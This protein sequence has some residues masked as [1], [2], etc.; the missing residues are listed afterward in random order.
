MHT[1][2]P[3]GP[4]PT[5]TGVTSGARDPELAPL[6]A[7]GPSTTHRIAEHVLREAW[8]TA[9]GAGDWAIALRSPSGRLAA[10]IS[11]FDPAM[12][13][14]AQLYRRA[15]RTGQVPRVQAEVTLHGGANLL[16]LE[17]L[18]PVA[19]AR[20]TAFHRSIRARAPG[21]A[22]LA[23]LVSVV[24]R[25]AR[26]ELPWCAAVIDANPTNV[27]A[28]STGEL[29]LIDPFY[30]DGPTLYG[31]LLT[32]ASRVARSIPRDDRAHMFELP[33]ASTGR[34]DPATLQAMRE[35]LAAADAAEV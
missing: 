14:N 8:W 25:Q 33:L 17:F 5:L 19:P 30:A 28:R 20:A 24:H 27:M 4:G 13:Y 3:V 6:A 2:H 12:P 1:E 7:F 31:T 15:E 34:P 22:E 26:A 9:C 35:A 10:R 16:I 11:P 21:V 29:V 23:E 18:Q 32:N